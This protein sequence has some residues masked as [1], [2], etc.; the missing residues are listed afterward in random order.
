M[1]HCCSG[2]AELFVLTELMVR[3]GNQSLGHSF[4]V[5]IIEP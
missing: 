1:G 2:G 3:F 4:L 5:A